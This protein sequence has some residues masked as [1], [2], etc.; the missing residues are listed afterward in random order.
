MLLLEGGVNCLA[1]SILIVMFN[2][3][4]FGSDY[5]YLANNNGCGQCALTGVRLLFE[6]GEYNIQG[7]AAWGYYS[8]AATIQWQ[9]LIKE[10]Q[11][12]PINLNDIVQGTDGSISHHLLNL[13]L[14]PPNHPS[15]VLSS[16]STKFPPSAS[17][18]A[19]TSAC[20]A[21]ISQS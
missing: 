18:S 4:I 19:I 21:I 20:S 2:N 15:S 13:H 12:S 5:C 3:T 9:H 11:Y 8:R 7:L 16:A 14:Y 10:I 17:T 6:G 1:A